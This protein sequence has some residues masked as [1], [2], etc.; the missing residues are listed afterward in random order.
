M[1][2]PDTLAHDIIKAIQ[3]LQYGNWLDTCTVNNG[4]ETERGTAREVTGVKGPMG[5]HMCQMMY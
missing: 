2:H 1:P 5:S 4:R 3:I